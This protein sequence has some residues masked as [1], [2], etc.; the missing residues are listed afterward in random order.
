MLSALP[1]GAFRDAVI[2]AGNEDKKIFSIRVGISHP[3]LSY[4]WMPDRAALQVMAL[5]F[6]QKYGVLIR[7]TTVDN[8]QSLLNEIDDTIEGPQSIGIIV[9]MESDSEYV[10][11]LPLIIYLEKKDST[12]QR[13]LEILIA[14]T[15]GRSHLLYY[16][17]K[18]RVN[19]FVKKYNYAK[20]YSSTGIRQFDTF[21]CRIGAIMFLKRALMALQRSPDNLDEH[22]SE[23]GLENYLKKHATF[24]EEDDFLV[25]HL[26]PTFDASEQISNKRAD[27]DTTLDSRHRTNK[28]PITIG[29]LR[30][31][32]QEEVPVVYEFSINSFTLPPSLPEN[33]EVIEGINPT[34]IVTGKMSIN[35][36]LLRTAYKYRELHFKK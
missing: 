30:Q 8:L 14:D 4:I 1:E 21:S 2:D 27:R 36:H 29:Q 34:I 17:T 15:L 9:S 32:H 28:K 23:G 5:K 20:I 24:N 3:D 31:R 7:E 11:A 22:A 13:A 12:G 16:R 26:P 33:V 10:H 25:D 35:T 6:H 18:Y 19:E